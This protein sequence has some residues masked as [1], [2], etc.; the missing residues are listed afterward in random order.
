MVLGESTMSTRT[1]NHLT[2]GQKS[3]L[4][5]AL[6]LRQRE[7]D[8]RIAAQGGVD[9][10]VEHAHDVLE[11][12][13][14]DAPQRDAEREV[15]LALTDRDRVELGEVSLALQRLADEGYGLCHDCG[16]QIP[17]DRLK[18]EP[19]ARRCVPCESAREQARGLPR[20]HTL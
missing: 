17:F 15:D 2:A 4:E 6:R 20:R 14:D 19:Q 16:A 11:Q 12:D 8:H 3:L 9:A 7:L 13:G 1:S 18:L 10:R 5:N